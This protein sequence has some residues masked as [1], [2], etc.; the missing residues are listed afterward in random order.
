MESLHKYTVS[1]ILGSVNIFLGK[2]TI[3]PKLYN[4]INTPCC[5]L[6]LQEIL[7]IREAM[8]IETFF[9]DISQNRTTS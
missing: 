1:A 7:S 8:L 5:L 2:Y 6:F 9:P 4:S 3:D